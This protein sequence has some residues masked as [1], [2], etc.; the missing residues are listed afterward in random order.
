M[1]IEWYINM[2]YSEP[3]KIYNFGEKRMQKRWRK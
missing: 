3:T 1:Y 2:V